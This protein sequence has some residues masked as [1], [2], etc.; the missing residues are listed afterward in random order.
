MAKEMSRHFKEEDLQAINRYIKKCSTS[1]VIREMQ[2]KTTLRFHLTSI[3]M[4]I[5]KNTSNNRCWRGCGEKGTLIHCWCGCKLVQPLW[6]AVWRFLSKLGME[7]LFDPATAFLS[8]YPKDLKSAH[9]SDA[10]I[11]MF[12]AAPFMIARLW[13]QPR[14]S[15]IDERKKKLWNIHIMEYYSVLKKN[16]IMAVAS[17]WTQLETIMLSEIS[18]SQRPEGC[19]L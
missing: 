13:N 4:V 3:R 18:Q 6:K 8:L 9:Y 7:P 10:A 2:I 16:K 12:I 11:S 19:F 14:C 17:K 1:L 15:S 5:I